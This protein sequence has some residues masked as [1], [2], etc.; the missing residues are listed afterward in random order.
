MKGLR[1]LLHQPVHTCNAEIWDEWDGEEYLICTDCTHLKEPR[2]TR[3]AGPV[4]GDEDFR[5]RAF[6]D[7]RAEVRT[8]M[9]YSDPW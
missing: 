3:V 7:A 4:A 6:E 8:H 2:I 5:R 1:Q 9:K